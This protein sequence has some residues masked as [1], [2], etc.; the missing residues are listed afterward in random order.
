MFA[1]EYVS[2]SFRDVCSVIDDAVGAALQQPGLSALEAP[3]RLRHVSATVASKYLKWPDP[4]SPVRSLPAEIRIIHVQSGYPA[5][6]ELMV[7]TPPE[8]PRADVRRFLDILSAAVDRS[9]GRRQAAPT[10][11]G[12]A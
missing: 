5:K 7:V 3:D 6:T 4:A 1:G 8:V 11:T 12:L 9:L 2:A 10:M